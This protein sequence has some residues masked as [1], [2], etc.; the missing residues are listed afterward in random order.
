MTTQI[1]TWTPDQGLS[2]SREPSIR[3]TRFGDGYEQRAANGI[4]SDLSKFP[5]SFS[6]RSLTEAQLIWNFLE[7]RGGTEAFLWS[8]P[9]G[10]A[11]DELFGTGNGSNTGFNLLSNGRAVIPIGSPIIT[12]TDWQG[13]QILYSTARTNS[14]KNS[15]NQ[16]AG[17][18]ALS[19]LSV[20]SCFTPVGGAF[21]LTAT[22]SD[23]TISCASLISVDTGMRTNSVWIRRRT[24][25]GTV[26]LLCPNGS[27]WTSITSLVTDSWARVSVSGI[28]GSGTTD[29]GIKLS[30]SGDEIDISFGQNEPGEVLTS[31]ILTASASVTITDYI[32]SGS[33][34][35]I[36]PAPIPDTPLRWTGTFG[37]LFVCKK[38][39]RQFTEY[40]WTISAEFQEVP[41][42]DGTSEALP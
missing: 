25:V 1:F 19:N 3:A 4:N 17:T 33:H 26:S 20:A 28:S 6:G 24:G 16:A 41:A 8:P 9:Y 42:N 22:S 13:T 38:F 2:E 37:R 15:Q 11:S 23:G 36:N 31:Y 10:T 27:T 12:R 39:S 18:Y 5:V 32:L 34:V 29:W 30:V 21:T 14:L 40:G 7:A 35:A